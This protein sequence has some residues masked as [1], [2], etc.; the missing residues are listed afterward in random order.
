MIRYLQHNEINKKKW[1]E[2]ISNASNAIVYAA[3][4]YLDIVS[5]GWDALVE[6]EY[7]SVF[8]LT[9]YKKYGFNYLRQP[10]FT[11]QLGVFAKGMITE[12]TVAEYLSLA[13]GKF[14]FI[15]INLN[16]ANHFSSGNFKITEMLTHHLHLNKNYEALLKN[17][18]EN[19]RRNISRAVKSGVSLITDANENQI[20]NLFRKNKGKEIASLKANDYKILTILVREAR[21]RNLVQVIGANSPEGN[22]CAGAIFMIGYNQVIFLFSATTAEAKKLGAMSMI[23]DHVIKS[24]ALK[25]SI[26][27]FEGSMDKNLAR[28]YKSFDSKE[29]VYLR[30]QWNNLPKFVR[31]I[32]K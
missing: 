1:D 5:P 30:L 26:L 28:F 12:N 25:N 19:Q 24:N 6:D 27:D 18:S 29:A 16:T 31:W 7:V 10:H 22:L 20:I 4:W 11:Q 3:S 17:Y 23:I 9:H 13:S 15:E 8:P 21:K 32:K 14:K 2:C